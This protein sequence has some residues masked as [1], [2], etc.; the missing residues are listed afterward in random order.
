MNKEKTIMNKKKSIP[1][2]LQYLAKKKEP[3]QERNILA[4]FSFFFFFWQVMIM[5]MIM[6]M[7]VMIIIGHF[8]YFSRKKKFVFVF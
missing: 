3:D 1:K 6:M 7:I 4:L 8:L 2:W 5:I